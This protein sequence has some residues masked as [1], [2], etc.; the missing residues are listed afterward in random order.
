MKVK[1]TGARL[2][3][4]GD[5]GKGD[6]TRLLPGKVVDS[7]S[8]ADDARRARFKECVKRGI[9]QKKPFELID[10]NADLTYDEQRAKTKARVKAEELAKVNGKPTADDA[11]KI[12]A[13][14]DAAAE[15]EAKARAGK[16]G[17]KG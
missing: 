11:S 1:N 4:L 14:A 16:Q 3:V 17:G 9:G 5:A 8:I 15:A 7:A 13:K 10:G 2:Y 6:G 12:E